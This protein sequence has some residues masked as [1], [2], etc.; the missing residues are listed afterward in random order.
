MN[1]SVNAEFSI[2]RLH[3]EDLDSLLLLYKHLHAEDVALPER[4]RIEA[5]WSDIFGNPSYRYFGGFINEQLVSSC[6][7]S[8]VPNLTRGCAPFGLIENV[9]THADHRRQGYGKALLAHALNSAWSCDCYKVMLMTG[10]K[11]EATL[12][13]YA[14]AGF[15]SQEKRAF[16]AKPKT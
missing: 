12:E 6:N 13:F 10:R 4:S 14:S 7:L 15:D 8:V 5:V 1:S 11:D 3:K 16:V 2:R 9:V